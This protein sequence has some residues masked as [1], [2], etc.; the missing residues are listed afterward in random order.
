[1]MLTSQKF[2][3]CN[4]QSFTIRFFPTILG[5]LIAQHVLAQVTESFSDGEFANTPA[6]SGNRTSFV[7]ENE[8][9]RLKTEAVS[10]NAFLSTSSN[11]VQNASWEFVVRMEFNPSGTNRT[12]VYI[13]SDAEDLSGSLNGYFVMIGDTPDEISLYRQSGLVKTKIIDGFNGRVNLSIVNAR[14]KVTRDDLG[15][16]EL[17]S[18][19]G[20]TGTYISEGIS[21]DNTFTQGSRFGVLCTYT[22]T[23]SDDF[24]FDDFVVT[25]LPAVDITPPEV[26]QFN[27]TSSQSIE[28]IFSE[29]LD[30]SSAEL[31]SNYVISA[32]STNPDQ[33]VLSPDEKKVSLSFS[34]HFANGREEVLLIS[35]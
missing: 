19:V 13:L 11:A 35:R 23:R 29:S 30:R 8:E 22:A 5:L 12:Q 15:N 28:L 7:V 20:L 21:F 33:A 4:R 16:W 2:C 32:G 24:Y 14:I 9:L 27:V 10:G 17:F 26:Q 3:F 25:G 6:W 34:Q 18:D 1:M 31:K